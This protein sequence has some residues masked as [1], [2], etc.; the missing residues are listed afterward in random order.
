MGAN[1][2]RLTDISALMDEMFGAVGTPERDEFRRQAYA[3]I[4]DQGD[5]EGY[6]EL[7]PLPE[8]GTKIE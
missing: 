7:P 8:I 4:M 5:H 2:D 3:E 1:N 6:T